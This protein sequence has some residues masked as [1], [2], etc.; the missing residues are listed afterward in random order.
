M[1]FE[2]VMGVHPGNEGWKTLFSEAEVRDRVEIAWAEEVMAEYKTTGK[3]ISA[4]HTLTSVLYM[5]KHDGK[6]TI[7]SEQA[8]LI[9]GN[10]NQA[11]ESCKV[12]WIDA[13]KRVVN[14]TRKRLGQETALLSFDGDEQYYLTDQKEMA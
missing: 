7:I 1:R 14:A 12:S 5:V 9:A 4:F 6:D 3:V 2:V 8:V 11:L 13:V 10:M